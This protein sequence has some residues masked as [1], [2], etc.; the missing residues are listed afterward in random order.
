M[1]K[2]RTIKGVKWFYVYNSDG[3]KILGKHRTKKEAVAQ[4]QA[5]EISKQKRHK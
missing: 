2:P 1:I 5:I 4:L 3:T